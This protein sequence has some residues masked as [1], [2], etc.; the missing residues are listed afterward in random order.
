MHH[1]VAAWKFIV[2]FIITPS[3]G[4]I[5][6]WKA[7]C[8]SR[9]STPHNKFE[10]VIGFI[11]LWTMLLTAFRF[12][13]TWKFKERL[14]PGASLGRFWVPRASRASATRPTLCPHQLPSSFSLCLALLRSLPLPFSLL[15]GQALQRL[16]QP[17]YPPIPF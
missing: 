4:K 15:H 6:I 16:S 3:C 14:T 11:T 17:C 2:N 1:L 10:A 12:Y 9:T 8:K 7:Q 13:A 5:R